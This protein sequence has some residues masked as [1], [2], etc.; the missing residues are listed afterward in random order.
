M[1]K[2]ISI[3]FSLFLATIL[4]VACSS[5]NAS[6]MKNDKLQ[7]VATNSIIA[8]ITKILQEI[9]FNCIVLYQ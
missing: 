7:V 3:V 4:L 1:K 2:K 9:K 6:K 5:S 8:D